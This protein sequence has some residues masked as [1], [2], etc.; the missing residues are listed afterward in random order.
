MYWLFLTFFA[1]RMDQNKSLFD[2]AQQIVLAQV[3]CLDERKSCDLQM[4][5]HNKEDSE[6]N[7][8][9]KIYLTY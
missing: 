3:V 2:I 5:L 8:S 4:H 6:S 9:Q 1:L 7:V